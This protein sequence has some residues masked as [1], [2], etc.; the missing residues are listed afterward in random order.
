[1]KARII[2]TGLIAQH[3]LGGVTW[4]YIQYVTG[5]RR[6]GYD[7]YYIEDS[8]AWPYALNGG[9]TGD[10]FVVSDC[11]QNVA[12][13]RDV[14]D[15][16]GLGE[17]WAYRCPIDGGWAGLPDLQREEVISS[18]ELLLN[19]SSTLLRPQ[20][21]RRIPRM[22]FIDSDPVFT[23]LKL[24]RG[25]NDFRAVV[26]AHDVFFSFGECLEEPWVPATGHAWLPTRQPVLLVAYD[27]AM[28]PPLDEVLPITDAVATA[29][30]IAAGPARSDAPVLGSFALELGPGGAAQPTP[31]PLWLP[32]HWV[33]LSSARSLAALG[34][35]EAAPDTVLRLRLASQ[36]LGL[37]R[38]D[39]GTE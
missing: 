10:D 37:R 11:S 36:L 21:Y 17:R 6:L 31:L 12:H 27:P 8:G 1:M 38:I 29:W 25:Q 7:V 2:V 14:M 24:A 39:E 28:T 34:L 4:D 19:I 22:A 35:L 33:A 32:A 9:E 5:L 18:T 20:E 26:D 16:F 15:R 23:Q 13:L 3:P 30:I